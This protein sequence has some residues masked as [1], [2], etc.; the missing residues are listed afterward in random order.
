MPNPSQAGAANGVLPAPSTILQKNAPQSAARGGPKGTPPKPKL[1]F[2]IR[3]LPPGLTKS[4]LEETLGDEWKPGNGRVDWA[5]FRKG[6]TSTDL[7]KTSKPSRYLLHLTDSAY[8]AILHD[9]VKQ[10]TFIDARNTGKDPVLIAPPSLEHALYARIPTG[11]RVRHDARQGQ[12]DQDPEYQDFLMSLTNPVNKPSAS[13]A[14]DLSAQKGEKV[15]TTPLIEHLREKK[16]KEKPGSKLSKHA[17]GES[18]DEKPDRKLKIGKDGGIV[19]KPK[20]LSRKEAAKEAV[21]VLNKEVGSA[22]VGAKSQ[23]NIPPAG[24]TSEKKRERGS[25]AA[26]KALLQRD[27]GIGPAPVKGRRGAKRETTAE[28]A[29][30]S[31]EPTVSVK[32]REIAGVT[33]TPEKGVVSGESSRPLKEKGRFSRAERR[34]H[35]AAIAE[36]KDRVET[37]ADDASKV[38]PPVA[39]TI[40][41]KPANVPKPVSAS[42]LPPTGPKL[43]SATPKGPA[44]SRQAPPIS[45][46][47]SVSGDAATTLAP[48]GKQGFLKHA[49]PS[50]GITEP[51]IEAALSA[52]G[53][54]ERVEIDKRKGFAY[55]EFVEPEGL[56]K[57][58]AAS[59]VKIAQGAVQVLERKDRP[60]KRI[61]PTQV[62]PS[63]PTAPRGNTVRGGAFAGRGRGGGRGG[64]IGRGGRGPQSIN[65]PQGAPTPA[66][67]SQG[68]PLAVPNAT[69]S[70][71]STLATTSTSITAAP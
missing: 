11:R 12:I 64:I 46:P 8:V 55:V 10:T 18:K 36:N 62:L 3:R 15:T 25:T 60:A 48:T 5:N 7:T 52:F 35:K 23:E 61:A 19:E 30:K 69:T 17:R 1:K 34:A 45:V 9:K 20:K 32:D 57:A 42:A 16:A 22:S 66:G 51:L 27:L 40:L 56:Q 28:S 47:P 26:A 44:A 24:S 50:Q 38:K 49:N 4:E 33:P 54:V 67:D 31:G 6:R 39:P 70:E 37:P 13:E 59:P 14:S 21:K 53:A 43:P 2:C 71:V 58:I 65:P 68:L 29:A 63:P 41:R